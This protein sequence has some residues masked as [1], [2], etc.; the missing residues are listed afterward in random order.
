MLDSGAP[1]TLVKH[2]AM[3]HNLRPSD[4]ESITISSCSN[5]PIPFNQEGD[6][7]LKTLDKRQIKNHAYYTPSID[8]NILSTADLR[9]HDLYMNERSNTIES[10]DGSIAANFVSHS[11]LSW[12]SNRHIVFPPSTSPKIIHSLQAKFPL[13]LI[14]RVFGHVNV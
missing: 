6:L 1:I 10:R 14:H 5:T 12:L 3:L 11:E 9:Q 7:I 4:P 13:A 2:K 8:N